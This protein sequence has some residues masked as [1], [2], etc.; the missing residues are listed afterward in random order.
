MKLNGVEMT[1]SIKNGNYYLSQDSNGLDA[2]DARRRG[3]CIK[4]RVRT[5]VAQRPK[6]A[7]NPSL[8]DQSEA[9]YG[10]QIYQ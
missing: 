7:G 6:H 4:Q 8:A 10:C 2:L 5:K 1:I 9:D 3:P